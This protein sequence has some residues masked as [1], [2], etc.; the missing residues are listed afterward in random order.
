MCDHQTAYIAYWRLYCVKK[1]NQYWFKF[2]DIGELLCVNQLNCLR[3][4]VQQFPWDHMVWFSLSQY[5]SGNDVNKKATP[6]CTSTCFLFCKLFEGIWNNYIDIEQKI[7]QVTFIIS[8]CTWGYISLANPIWQYEVSR[9]QRL[10]TNWSKWHL[11]KRIFLPTKS[12]A[13]RL[14]LWY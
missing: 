10:N 5:T 3:L 9:K 7:I 1:M 12:A 4:C 14:F 11:V 6:F 2:H 13:V 8:L